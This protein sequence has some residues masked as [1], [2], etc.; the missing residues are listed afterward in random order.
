MLLIQTPPQLERVAGWQL[1]RAHERRRD[2]AQGLQPERSESALRLVGESHGRVEVEGRVHLYR[3]GDC[4]VRGRVVRPL[5]AVALAEIRLL[6][7]A[8]ADDE[9]L[10][11]VLVLRSR[12]QKPGALGRAQ[13]LVTVAGVDVRPQGLEIERNLPRSVRAVD[14]REDARLV[15]GSADLLHR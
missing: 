4:E 8:P 10:D 12:P 11:P 9:R 7:G 13:P 6:V 5:P 14:D 1:H 2:A 15:G 3:P